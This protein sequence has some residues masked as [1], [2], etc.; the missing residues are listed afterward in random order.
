MVRHNKD[1]QVC[2][3]DKCCAREFENLQAVVKKFNLSG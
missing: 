2:F 3:C 1:V